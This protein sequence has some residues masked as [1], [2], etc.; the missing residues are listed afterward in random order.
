MCMSGERKA[1]FN[2]SMLVYLLGVM[3]L[4]FCYEFVKLKTG[5]GLVFVGLV[6]IYILFL[7]LSGELVARKYWARK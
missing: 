3:F 1:R 6:L 5:G 7:R 2:P 4:G